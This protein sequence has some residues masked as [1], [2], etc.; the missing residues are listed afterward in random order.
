GELK[1]RLDLEEDE[2]VR[3]ALLLAIERL[4]GAAE[5]MDPTELKRRIKNTVEKLDGPP[6]SWLDPKKLPLPRLK[7]GRKLDADGL[8][9]LL[10]RQSRVK[11]MRADIE[12][13]PLF[14]QIDRKT[15][16]DLAL[17]VLQAFFGSKAD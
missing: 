7:N 10:Y 11:D 12:A 8:L 3:D 16:G 1:S 9:Y 6:V 14:A 13:R 2:D 15:S 4:T 17:A 5:A